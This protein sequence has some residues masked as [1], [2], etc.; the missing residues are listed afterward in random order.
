MK[1]SQLFRQSHLALTL[2]PITIRELFYLPTSPCTV[3]IF[4]EGEFK[5]LVTKGQYLNPNN[6]KEIISSGHAKVFVQEF[7]RKEIIELQQTNLR[8]LTR[9]F[10]MGNTIENCK[11]QLSLLTVNL[12]YL[13]EDP[14][15]DESLNLQYQSLKILFKYLYDNPKVHEQIYHD[16]KKQ[17]HHYVFS[18]PFLSSLFLIGILKMSHVY[19]EK[20][21]ESLFITS[22]FKDIGMSAIPVDKLDSDE[23]TDNDKKILLNHAK[24]SVQILQN[25]LQLSPNLYK[26]IEEHHNLSTLPENEE[27]EVI[28]TSH[29][30]ISGFETV[31][32]IITDI[33]AAMISSRPFREPTSLYEALALVKKRV[34]AQYPKEFKLVVGYFKNFF[35]NTV[36]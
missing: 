4:E 19:S 22:Y 20:E 24:L 9:S 13:F 31:M 30:T 26:V 3:Y 15:N 28:T 36:G 6:L 29:V 10:S 16:Y 1:A 34:S 35:T 21:I 17:G 33:V 12:R 23:L 14:T 7:E 8:N 2:V 11:K 18:Q 25:R 27:G 5:T 32:V